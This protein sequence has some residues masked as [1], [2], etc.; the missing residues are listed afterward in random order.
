MSDANECCK[1][2][3]PD[4]GVPTGD[5]TKIADLDVYIAETAGGF[6]GKAVLYLTD[7][8]GWAFLNNRLLADDFAK[9]AN[10]RVYIPDFFH[11]DA[12]EA[13]MMLN[14]ELR[15]KFDFPAWKA[16]HS[17]QNTWPEITGFVEE[18]RKHHGVTAIASV[19]Y[20]WGGWA[21]LRLGAT[22]LVDA[23]AVGHPSLVQFPAD[24]ENIKKPSLF[25]CA[26]IDEHF[27]LE[28]VEKAKAILAAKN[29]QFS[30]FYIYPG[31]RHGFAVRGRTSDDK[32]VADAAA[33]ARDEAVNF[34][35]AHL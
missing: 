22:D 28:I 16:K 9:L 8:F 10:V 19:G 26:E 3:V 24:I 32:V 33:A 21:S 11:G 7:I 25:L 12:P 20:C 6:N 35:K 14:P 29:P 18:V 30:V 15:A 5:T 13:K 2:G 1:T 34:F 31:T 17:E 4:E 23:V 27:N